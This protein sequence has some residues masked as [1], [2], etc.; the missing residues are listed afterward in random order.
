MQEHVA[1]TITGHAPDTEGR[2][3]GPATR[4]DMVEAVPALRD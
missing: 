4:K 1:Y 2:K 3:Y